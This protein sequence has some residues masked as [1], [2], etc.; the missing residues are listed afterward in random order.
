MG[1]HRPSRPVV[2]LSDGSPIDDDFAVPAGAVLRLTAVLSQALTPDARDEL[3]LQL[4]TATPE[5]LYWVFR[6]FSAAAKDDEAVVLKA[7]ELRQECLAAASD[8]CKDDEK[9]VLTAVARNAR[10]LQWA[11]DRWRDDRH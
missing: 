6:G 8:S 4:E 10:C 5:R 7:V 2:L 1:G 3:L 11:S 9:I